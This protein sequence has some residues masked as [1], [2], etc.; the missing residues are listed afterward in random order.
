VV[1]GIVLPALFILS[2]YVPVTQLRYQ[3]GALGKG[4]STLPRPSGLAAE[5]TVSLAEKGFT[6]R[7]ITEM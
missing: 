7:G 4:C 2:P 3:Q 6:I 5:E 1:C